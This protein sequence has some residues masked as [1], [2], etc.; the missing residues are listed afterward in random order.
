MPNHML[1]FGLGYTASHL[2]D[3]LRAD[4]WRVTGIKRAAAEGV[5]AYD[6]QAA[7]LAALQSATHILSSVPPVAGQ[8]D[9][10]LSQYGDAIASAP[11]TWSGYLSSTGVYGDAQGAWVDES[12]ALGAG[13]RS[14]RTDADIAWQELRAWQGFRADMRIFR[15][16]GIYGPGRSALD[17][18]TQGKAHRIDLPQ[19]IFS[20]VHVDDIVSGV[21]ASFA[22]PV[23]VYNLADDLP[24]SQNA[25]IAYA[26]QLLGIDPP[27]IQTLEEA[28]LSPMA[29]A[30]YAE[31][32]KVSNQKAKRLLNW[33]PLYP[34]FKQGLR[35]IYDQGMTKPD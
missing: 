27:P 19:Q 34:T 4:G 20:R 14:A 11:A 18:V 1:I 16:P 15:L 10:V 3:A 2:A 21:I 22:G 5:I 25:V 9:P 26:S 31:N 24:C 33:Q 6:D 17:R 32:R 35:E 29:M 30:F 7:V 12:T 28:A 23:G 8:G 13:R